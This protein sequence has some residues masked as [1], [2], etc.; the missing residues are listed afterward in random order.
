[1]GPLGATPLRRQ[2]EKGLAHACAREA[3]KNEY[4]FMLWKKKRLAGKEKWWVYMCFI[5][6]LSPA[7]ALLS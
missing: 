1:M 7:V 5:A 4:I 2:G 3:T 6:N